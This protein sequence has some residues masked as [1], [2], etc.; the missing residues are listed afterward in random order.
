MVRCSPTAPGYNQGTITVNHDAGAP[1]TVGTGCNGVEGRITVLAPLGALDL[2]AGESAT[3]TI[4]N[5]GVGPLYIGELRFSEDA[6]G[7]SFSG[8]TLPVTLPVG[9]TLTWSVDCT[10][11]PG[12]QSFAKVYAK[13][14][15]L[16]EGSLFGVTCTQPAI[17][18]EPPVEEDP[19]TPPDE[20]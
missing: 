2:Q 9:G 15:G 5:D 12:Y 3:A 11:A 6:P 18:I 16:Q 7:L 20:K 1:L 4:R 19:Y 17:W 13:H 14:D 10:A 8:V